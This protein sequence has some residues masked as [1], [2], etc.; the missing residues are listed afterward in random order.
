MTEKKRN[1]HYNLVMTLKRVTSGVARL[2]DL[3]PGQLSSEET[4]QQW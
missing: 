4:L 2:R 1:L 3:S